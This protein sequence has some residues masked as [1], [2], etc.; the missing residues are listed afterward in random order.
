MGREE[1]RSLSQ[2]AWPHTENSQHLE[3]TSITKPLA[4]IFGEPQLVAQ[5]S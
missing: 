1:H 5:K 4:S 2:L 3:H